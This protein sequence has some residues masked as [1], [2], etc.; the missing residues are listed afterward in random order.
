MANFK[1]RD[2]YFRAAQRHLAVCKELRD[3]IEVFKKKEENN[4]S[5]SESEIL[6]KNQLLCDLYYLTGYVI[7]CTYCMVIFSHFHNIEHKR[8][9]KAVEGATGK[10]NI[11]F[12]NK[13][14]EDTFVVVGESNRQHSLGHFKNVFGENYLNREV[15]IDLSL[16]D[17]CR[18]LFEEYE[19]EVRY[20]KTET[21]PIKSNL[22]YEKVFAFLEGARNNFKNCNAYHPR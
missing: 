2:E 8:D 17:K 18:K 4:S 22:T 19:A 14:N 20:F 21:E 13:V 3:R 15:P 12:S 9:L 10:K 16:F 1:V 6:L 5:L 7:E 11:S